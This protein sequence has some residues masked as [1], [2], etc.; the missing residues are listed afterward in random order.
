VTVGSSEDGGESIAAD[1]R[2]RRWPLVAGVAVLVC[3]GAVPIVMRILRKPLIERLHAIQGTFTGDHAIAAQTKRMDE[4]VREAPTEFDDYLRVLRSGS[5]ADASAAGAILTHVDVRPV[6]TAL[7]E[8][9][10]GSEAQ[11]RFWATRILLPLDP[12]D[13]RVLDTLREGLRSDDVGTCYE[14]IFGLAGIPRGRIT[15]TP[16][17]L[18]DL[19]HMLGREGRDSAIDVRSLASRFLAKFGRAA[20]PTLVDAL[21]DPNAAYWTMCSLEAIGADA[22]DAIPALE[23]LAASKTCDGQDQDKARD[24]I[25][26]IR[27]K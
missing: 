19:G 8:M 17:L 1:P 12:V 4:L 6:G 16:G 21:K 10:R 23:Q 20:V 7:R 11:P 18:A 27:G 2:K 9:S 22:S 26:K 5:P 25:A 3:L 13:D 24:T 14:A 15:P